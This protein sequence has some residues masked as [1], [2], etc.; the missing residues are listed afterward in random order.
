VGDGGV[1]GDD[2]G[3]VDDGGEAVAA[4]VAAVFVVVVGVIV[5]VVVAGLEASEDAFAGGE[6]A[7]AEDEESVVVE[8]VE[9][10]GGLFDGAEEVGCGGNRASFEGVL[11]GVVI[12]SED[13]ESS[14]SVGAV[15]EDGGVSAGAEDGESSRR[16][17][18]AGFGAVVGSDVAGAMGH[19]LD[20]RRAGVAAVSRGGWERAWRLRSGYSSG[21]R[22]WMKRSLEAKR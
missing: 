14:G 2:G 9:V 21:V 13:V 6:V 3:E 19:A 20:H 17:S 16:G 5:V 7:D 8:V 1:G 18:P 12:A 11:A 15:G 10:L 22:R 4:F